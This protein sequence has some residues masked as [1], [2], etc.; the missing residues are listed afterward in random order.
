M[1]KTNIL[2]WTFNIL[3]GAF[4]LMSALP[5]IVSAQ[6]AVEGFTK[7]G[8][9]I[10]LLP[11]LGVAKALGVIA[12]LIPTSKYPRIKEWAYAGLMFDLLGASWCV[13]SAGVR[14]ADL[15]FM[16]FPLILGIAAYSFY[17]KKAGTPVP[18]FA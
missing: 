9:P 2:F 14:G 18:A 1:K 8:M 12:I 13:Y 17:S 6:I 7:M 15:A 4:M 16:A 5:D 3:F 10:Y 11:F